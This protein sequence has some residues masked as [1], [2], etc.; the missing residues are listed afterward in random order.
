MS[1]PAPLP[2]HD[3]EQAKR[4]ATGPTTSDP[5][6]VSRPKAQLPDGWAKYDAGDA[7]AMI[8]AKDEAARNREGTTSTT[9]MA[10][11]VKQQAH[12]ASNV[13]SENKTMIDT[14]SSVLPVSLS[15]VTGN[16]SVLAQGASTK[17]AQSDDAAKQDVEKAAEVNRARMNQ[18]HKALH[19]PSDKPVTEHDS[20]R[21][22][23]NFQG[24]ARAVVSNN[25]LRRAK[26][27]TGD[28]MTKAISTEHIEGEK[29]P[30]AR[31]DG[32]VLDKSQRANGSLKGDMKRMLTS[33]F[34]GARPT[35]SH[36]KL[37]Q[38]FKDQIAE[39]EKE[40]ED[41]LDAGAQSLTERE[42]EK[43]KYRGYTKAEFETK[44]DLRAEND[45]LDA[46][47]AARGQR[48]SVK[49][50]ELQY[51]LTETEQA[52]HAFAKSTVNSVNS[53]VAEGR[54]KS[55]KGLTDERDALEE[56][57]RKKAN[58]GIF[59]SWKEHRTKQE[60]DEYHEVKSRHEEMLASHKS[61]V[62]SHL[63]GLEEKKSKLGKSDEDKM[64][65][66]RIDAEIASVKKNP[67]QLLSEKQI[68]DRNTLA[69][70]RRTLKTYKD[71]GLTE[72]QQNRRRTINDQLDVIKA[73]AD[74][75]ITDDQRSRRDAAQKQADDFRYIKQ[76]GLSRE[77][78]AK[79][80]RNAQE[81][82]ELKETKRT[83][84]TTA[85]RNQV[86]ALD[87]KMS[88]VHELAAK[89]DDYVKRHMGKT[90]ENGGVDALALNREATK[91][92]LVQT[93]TEKLALSANRGAE[94]VHDVSQALG[95]SH[96]HARDQMDKNNTN[97]AMTTATVGLL[98]QGAKAAGPIGTMAVTGLDAVR[99][100]S[101][102]G[103]NLTG[104]LTADSADSALRKQEQASLENVDGQDHTHRFAEVRDR[105]VDLHGPA[106]KVFRPDLTTSVT[107]IGKEVAQH[108]G[109]DDKAEDLLDTAK[110]PL[111]DA[112]DK[113]T[114]TVS[115]AVDSILPEK[116]E[117][118]GPSV[119][120]QVTSHA[121]DLVRSLPQGDMLAEHVPSALESAQKAVE[122]K[123]N[124]TVDGLKDK[125]VAH[126]QTRVA[127]RLGH[128]K[129]SDASEEAQ[130]DLAARLAAKH[131]PP[132]TPAPTPAVTTPT[133]TTP[134]PTPTVT[135]PE[136]AP[137]VSAPTPAPAPAPAPAP[138][139][140]PA[141]PMATG[142]TPVRA[143]TP[144]PGLWGRFKRWAGRTARSAW[145]GLKG[146]FGR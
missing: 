92:E 52:S 75:G 134:E 28:S 143:T 72:E 118:S 89:D 21:A 80:M 17:I 2:A 3:D 125:V 38:E 100:V 10:Q 78:H 103:A 13:I 90:I 47:K 115:N 31:A 67:E 109:L 123:A 108:T 22:R 70:Q 7:D 138:S 37:K 126:A 57:G 25:N 23:R 102:L 119:T 61:G 79:H 77:D 76:H 45:A 73:D 87:K 6:A 106:D 69:N 121:Q 18:M 55:M 146:L 9:R 66:A 91:D 26:L 12:T 111:A 116:S 14:A 142:V 97:M 40:K 20:T 27:A 59:G 68:A 35:G 62:D 34:P 114:S 105:G 127:E 110:K 133:V 16:L 44:K 42:A 120:E 63:K 84:L 49:K 144:K 93:T 43:D 8:K 81:I 139:P 19:A 117:D 64:A 141:V 135:S 99:K 128:Y 132:P 85:Q 71:E 112:Q 137:I 88:G 94:K 65:A 30:V 107:Q 50:K 98:R 51:N 4:A 104:S 46:T 131:T 24:I 86:A 96:E 41:I 32:T 53:E 1:I 145:N 58:T 101:D 129:A 15:E 33:L 95:G 82:A 122:E 56:V 83:G 136:P 36:I 60:V 124:D 140:A 39:H 5:T 74:H 29:S 11:S 48:L 130:S 113:V 54:E